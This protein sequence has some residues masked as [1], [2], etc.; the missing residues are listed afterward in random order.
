MS[1][2][3]HSIIHVVHFSLRKILFQGSARYDMEIE[4]QRFNVCNKPT[5]RLEPALF[6]TRHENKIELVQRT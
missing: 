4:V 6:V 2:K 3:V 1:T 5:D